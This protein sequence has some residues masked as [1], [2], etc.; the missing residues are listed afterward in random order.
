MTEII[1]KSLFFTVKKYKKLIEST[2]ELKEIMLATKDILIEI[3]Q[4]LSS[5]TRTCESI[6]RRKEI[7][8]DLISQ[9][10]ARPEIANSVNID[11]FKNNLPCK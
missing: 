2:T 1:D 7:I 9:I 5:C 6:C 10:E 11:I 3:D 8:F 4:T